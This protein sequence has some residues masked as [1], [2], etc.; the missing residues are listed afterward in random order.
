MPKRKVQ[1]EKTKMYHIYNRGIDHQC[2]CRSAMDYNRLIS[3][4]LRIAEEEKIKLHSW[5]F[6]PTHFHLLAEQLSERSI[7]KFMGRIFCG[8][9]KYFNKK[10]NRKGFLFESRFKAK[11]VISKGYYEALLKYI[12]NNS[13]RHG[14]VENVLEWPFSH[15]VI[16]QQNFKSIHIKYDEDEF[17]TINVMFSGK[18]AA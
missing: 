17:E 4:T 8:Y 11:E 18:F 14:I 7:N 10:Y 2:I 1:F 16:M 12:D 9:T 6:L 15:K 3:D 13:I 5:C